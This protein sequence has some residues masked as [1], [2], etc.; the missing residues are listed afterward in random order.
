MLYPNNFEQKIGF[1]KI[2]DLLKQNCVSSRGVELID[3]MCFTSVFDDIVLSLSRIDEVISLLTETAD[4]LPLGNIADLRACMVRT[5]VEGT[6][7]DVDDVVDIRSN[8]RSLHQLIQ[9]IKKQD[10]A[11]FPQMHQLVAPIGMFPQ[12]EQRIDAL[13]DKYGRIKD[14]ASSELYSIRKSITQAQG[15]ISKTLHAILKKAQ[16]DGIVEKDATPTLREGRLVIPVVAMNKRRIGGIVHDESATGKTAYIEPTAVVEVNNRLRELESEERREII[17]IL[18]EFTNEVRPHY[19]PLEE[20][21]EFLALIDTLKAKAHFSIKI[22]AIKPHLTT[23][24]EIDW[25]EARHPLLQIALEKQGKKIE[26]LTIHLNEQQRI[27]LISGPNAGGKSVCLKTVGLLQYML[28]CGLPIP[29]MERSVAGVFERVFIDIGDEQSIENDLSTYSSHL[30]NMKYCIR[31]G[32]AKTLLLIDEF[33]TGTE[34]QFGGAIAQAVLS[35]LNELKLFGVITTHY[36]NLKQFATDT[37]GIINGAMLYDRHRMQPLFALSMGNPG[38]SFAIEIARKI[39]LPEDVIAEASELAGSDQVDFD[40]YLQD[41]ARDKRYWESKRQQIR[42]RDKKLERITTEYE[43]KMLELKKREKEMMR[44]A[45]QEAAD[46]LSKANAQ[47]EQTIR[48]IKESQADKEK[49]K[50]VR[51]EMTHMKQQLQH[52]LAQREKRSKKREAIVVG[53]SVTLAGQSVHGEVLD[54]NGKSAIVA[55]GQLKSTVAISKLEKLSANAV[56][57]QQQKSATSKQTTAALRDRQLNF[58]QEIDVRGMRVDEALQAVIYFI[59]DAQMVGVSQ[60]RILHGTG[61]GALRQAIRDYLHQSSMVASYRDEHVQ[62][63]GAGITV[64][65]MRH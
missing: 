16:E 4:G 63:G 26:P 44:Q 49:T 48:T 23:A 56:K 52:D 3:A 42:E 7:L 37:P 5:Q 60:V 40:K 53:D 28:Q 17:R 34:P 18:V 64:V 29:L 20:A 27:L 45:K 21:A 58:K 2:R 32:N 36:S 65:E 50:E 54:I 43:T 11:R 55:F 35:R 38:S 8:L 10:E 61:T 13:I 22:S 62:F 46:L 59:D 15:S 24:C 39:G 41:I 19:Q 47:I 57:K 31:N 1:D 33:G 12:L 30:L 25:Y 14:N 6:Y 9:Y 51:S